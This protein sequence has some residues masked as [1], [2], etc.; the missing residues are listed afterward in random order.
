MHLVIASDLLNNKDWYYHFNSRLNAPWGAKTHSWTN[1]VTALLAGGALL[2]S[3]FMSLSTALY[4]WGFWLPIIFNTIAAWAMLWAIKPL[5]PTVY[6][7][8]FVL[9]AF[10]LNPFLNTFFIPLRVDYDFL[11]ITLSIVYWGFLLRLIRSDKT[12]IAVATA[13]VASLGAWTSISFIVLLLIGLSFLFWLALIKQTMRWQ[14]V[15]LFLINLC[16]GFA[17][18]IYLEHR[19]F[20][21]VAHDIISITH[22]TFLLLL[23]LS[24]TIYSKFLQ[25]KSNLIKLAYSFVAIVIIFLIM[26]WLFPG[27]YRG[28]YNQAEPYLLRH[29]FPTLSEFYSPF[30][31]DSSLGLAIICYFIIGA[32]YCYYLYLSNSLCISKL[33]FLWAAIITTLLTAYMYRWVEFA[34]PLNILLMSFFI[35]EIEN[36]RQLFRL[37]FLILMVCLPFLILMLAKDYFVDSQQLCQQQLYLIL[38]DDFLNQ[39]QF[40]Q[41][42]IIF[43]HS[44]YGPLLLYSTRYAIVATNDHHNPEGLKDSILFFKSTESIVEQMIL[45][46]KVDLVLLCPLEHH[47]EFNPQT[48]PWLLAVPLPKEYSQWQLY[49]VKPTP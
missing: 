9:S 48:S 23:T 24:F 35:R 44:N 33:L 47:T 7:Q 43:A 20:F 16:L 36:T 2:L 14:I 34:T 17:I 37:P 12:A 1:L 41:D 25:L 26:N 5:K 8:L 18:I 27:F 45:R 40:N 10:L 21:T 11:L 15:S 13:L 3:Y 32:G 30:N 22:L 49:R 39:P 38:R 29:F 4:H 46:R 19:H 31:I 6:Q 42:K 28:P